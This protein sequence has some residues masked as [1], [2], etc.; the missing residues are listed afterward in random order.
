MSPSRRDILTGMGGL[1]IGSTIG[2]TSSREVNAKS[3]DTT[4]HEQGP[5]PLPW[6][7]K[8]LDPDSIAER[9]YKG[10]FS[11]HCMYA[12]FEAIIGELADQVGR[13]FSSFPFVM[14]EYGA[15]GVNGWGSLCGTLNGAAAAIQ[16][17]SETPSE[18]IDA[19]YH[20]HQETPLPTTRPRLPADAQ[21]NYPAS[22]EVPS[23]TAGSILCH[24]AV[25]K[26]S[27]ESGFGIHSPQKRQRCSQTAASVA[28]KTVELLN[29]QYGK[30]FSTIQ[31]PSNR[32]QKCVSC[33]QG[34]GSLRDNSQG[35]MR[36]TSCHTDLRPP[37]ERR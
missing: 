35:K 36:C 27:Q 10:Y 33:H 15:G 20:W 13:P 30:K 7:Y 37:H 6:P 4:S 16:L 24:I 21:G 1:L 29:R 14:M 2:V 12:S 23:S 31:K 19:L 17:L 5:P 25:S 22:E 11:H 18:L 26:W 8:K 28:K 32:D 34:L 3:P 9:A